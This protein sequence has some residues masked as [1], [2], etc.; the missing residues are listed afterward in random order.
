MRAG[1]AGGTRTPAG[2]GGALPQPTPIL[3]KKYKLEFAVEPQCMKKIE[4]AKA[5][6]S[7]KYPRG[8]PLGMLLEEALDVYL[9][10]HSPERKK[11]RREKRRARREEKKNGERSQAESVQD[12]NKKHTIKA[13]S[14]KSRGRTC[15]TGEQYN[16]YIPQAVREA[17]FTRDEGRCT[18]IGPEGIRCNS[19]WNLHID[20]IIP[21]ARGGDHSLQNLRLLCGRHNQFEAEKAYGREFMS[22][23]RRKFI[24]MRK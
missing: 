17:V 5:L 13:G 19:T 2:T 23:K 16:R 4:E 14:S 11:Q 12:D 20:H 18:F 8:V 7:R 15:S 21:F 6:L 9:D 3:K 24:P 1:A 10:K 22:R